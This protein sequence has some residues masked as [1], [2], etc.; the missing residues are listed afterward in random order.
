[1]G[2]PGP[3]VAAPPPSPPAAAPSPGDERPSPPHER[4][5]HGS[6]RIERWSPSI[7][8]LP[9][10]PASGAPALHSAGGATGELGSAPWRP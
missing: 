3:P 1:M 6:G 7:A 10:F 5:G 4:R 2:P 9:P 8:A